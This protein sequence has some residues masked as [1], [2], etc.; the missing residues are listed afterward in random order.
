MEGLEDKL[1]IKADSIT[2]MIKSLESKAEMIK[3]EAKN[4]LAWAENKLL[5][6]KKMKEYLKNQLK[7]CD[8]AKIETLRNKI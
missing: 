6:T 7:I 8:I 5:K 2:F 1:K 3:N 4:Q